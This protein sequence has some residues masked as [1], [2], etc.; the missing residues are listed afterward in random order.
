MDEL[1]QQEEVFTAAHHVSII[2]A[3]LIQ[4]MPSYLFKIHYTSTFP[5]TSMSVKQALFLRFARQGPVWTSF[6][7]H[8]CHLSNSYHPPP[9]C[10]PKKFGKQYKSRSSSFLFAVPPYILNLYL[11]VV[12]T[13]HLCCS[14]RLVVYLKSNIHIPPTPKILLFTV[15]SVQCTSLTFY[16]NT[17]ASV[18]EIRDAMEV[19]P[20]VANS[21]CSLKAI[22][23]YLSCR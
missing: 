7:H 23:F 18:Q 17:S 15:K 6:I 10:H 19:P 2:W 13:D 21:H 12:I 3:T 9:L 20:L 16:R 5:S 4:Y 14:V 1:T 11:F 8:K 22:L